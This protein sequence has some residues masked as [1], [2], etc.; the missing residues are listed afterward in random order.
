MVDYVSEVAVPAEYAARES[1]NRADLIHKAV[2]AALAVLDEAYPKFK[3]SDGPMGDSLAGGLDEVI[4]KAF[5][6]YDDEQEKELQEYM[7]L[8]RKYGRAKS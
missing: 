4:T 6:K 1:S 7:R 3:K 2:S 8:N 5:Y